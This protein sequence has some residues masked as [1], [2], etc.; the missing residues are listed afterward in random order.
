MTHLVFVHG[1]CVRNDADNQDYE[2]DV[3]R[4]RKSFQSMGFGGGEVE[5]YDPYWGKFGA[6]ASYL[7]LEL[8]G[9]VPLILGRPDDF[10]GIEAELS[11]DDL[12]GTAL[13]DAADADFAAI[14]NSLS[15]VLANPDN[16]AG[17]QELALQIADYL[18][19]LEDAEGI[20]A[21]PAWMITPKPVNDEDF[22]AR[23]EQAARPESAQALGLGEALK[24]AS[25]WLIGKG[26]G[27][28]D[29]PA[30]RLARK[31]T[32]TLAVFLGDA[33]I[34]LKRGGNGDDRF[35][36]IRSEISIDLV[37]ASKKS[38]ANNE[39]LIVVGHSMG[40]NILY[41]MLSDDK[42]VSKLEDQI[43]ERLKIDLLLTV[44]TQMG[45]LQE[46]GLFG[47]GEGK[48]PKSCK[49]WWHVYNKMD[50]LSFGAK[51]VFK[52]VEQFHSDT[53]ANIVDAHGAYFTSPVFQR[54]LYKRL[55]K[56]GLAS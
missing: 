33:F 44:G 15:I 6:P 13:R 41:D 5:F 19:A 39:K 37:E 47:N 48:R 32:P 50:V 28:I 42:L 16:P 53:N 34:Y 9:D 52:E 14:V 46:L 36:K 45:I 49:A 3:L 17:D 11:A 7:S 30:A 26:I 10:T 2:E 18:V 56:A 25:K 31:L 43:G 54:R 24:K 21:K 4:R 51:N 55:K 22:I 12:T 40:A 29:G 35:H 23:L 20:G 8:E 38:K 27:I 1:V